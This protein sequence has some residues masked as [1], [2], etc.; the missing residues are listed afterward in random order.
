MFI[1]LVVGFLLWAYTLPLPKPHPAP[2]ATLIYGNGGQVIGHFSEQNRVDVALNQVPPVVVNAVVSTEDRHFF[3]EGAINPVSTARAVFSDLTGRG[4]QGGSTIT[5]QYVK[6][7]Y[8]SPRRSLTRKVEEAVIAFRLSQSQSKQKILG[9]YL[10]TIYWGRGAYGVEAASQAFFGKDVGQLGVPE[11]SLLAGI[12]KDPGG[13]DPAYDPVLAEKYQAESLKAMVR[14]K[15]ITQAQAN[16]AMAEPFSKYVKP[17]ATAGSGASGPAGSDY[18]LAAVRAQL[19]QAFGRP[20]V[21]GGG[22]RVYTT[23]DPT[24]QS[25][26]YGSV[27]GS[28]AKALHPDKG[29]PSAAA[30]TVDDQGHILA[31]VGGQNFGRSSVNLAL[32]A[33]GGGTGRQAGST[34]KAFM[35]ATAIQEGYTVQ[36]VIPSPP[37]ITIPNGNGDGTDWKVTNYEGEALAP[38]M[39][40]TDATANSV[41]TVYAQV[42]QKL[43]AAK[44]DAMAEAMGIPKSALPHPYLSQ[45]LGTADVSPL[46]MASAY[47]TLASGGVYRSPVMITKITNAAGK[48]LTVPG[49]PTSRPVL[50]PSQAA[51]EDYVLQQ[52]VQRGTGTAAGNVG[53]PIAGKTGTTENSGDAWFVGYTPKITTAVWMGYADKV[54]TMDGFRGLSSVT[55]GTIPAELWHDYMAA[56][57]RSEPQLGGAF[58]A[59]GSLAGK[60]LMTAG[61]S[62]ST[63]SGPS[64][65][66]SSSTTSTTAPTSTTTTKKNPQPGPKPSPT[67][68]PTAPPPPPGPAPTTTTTTT[69][70]PSSTTTLAS[71]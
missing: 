42:V 8:L 56:A 27:Y 70:V 19:Y 40:L 17:P 41:N 9:E 50:T 66:S 59:P 48:A 23:M 62:T 26:A 15:K 18:F 6:Q 57:L 7:A 5:Q 45:V 54:R 60:D 4:L 71:G 47:A 21:D 38:A 39:S 68:S 12:I 46:D 69:T 51:I 36:S 64:S 11:A 34:F 28:S 55:G 58:P 67:T 22:L 49:R 44:L 65:T 32:G 61:T 52:V 3:S 25:E 37:Q 14:D 2:Q 1:L 29:D 30:V 24:L 16:A 31:M 10:N 20:T 13:A 35:L 43:G 53:F 63:T 33:A